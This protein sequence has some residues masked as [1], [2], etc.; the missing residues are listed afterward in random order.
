MLKMEDG[1]EKDELECSSDV[2]CINGKLRSNPVLLLPF[3]FTA[4]FSSLILF[5]DKSLGCPV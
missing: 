4:L 2:F 3:Q 1:C 5:I